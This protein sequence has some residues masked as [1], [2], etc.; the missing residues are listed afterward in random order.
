[1]IILDH[2]IT[3]FMHM[4]MTKISFLLFACIISI[5]ALAQ[6]SAAKHEE[7]DLPKDYLTKEFHAGR[8]E[9]LRAL[10]PDN[11]V[12]AVF[13][14]PTRNFSND[15]EYLYHAN[16]DMYYFSGYKE[17]HSM[18][19][20]FKTEQSDSI[21][22]KFS[23]LLF[24]QKKNAQAEQWTGK[25]LGSEAARTKLGIP[26]SFNGEEFDRFPIDFSKFDKILFD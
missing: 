4:K 26:M 19:L 15:V 6:P 23:E 8:R 21:G 2:T 5:S 1:M 22:N 16:P 14:F 18:L 7:D 3:F 20:I 10:L 13:A 9:A 17:P 25:R 12:M 11:S 24:V